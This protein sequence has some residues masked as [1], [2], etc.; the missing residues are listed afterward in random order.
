MNINELESINNYIGDVSYICTDMFS[1]YSDW[2][3]KNGY[4][5]YVEPSTY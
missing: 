1:V 2:C 5:H 4:T 3:D